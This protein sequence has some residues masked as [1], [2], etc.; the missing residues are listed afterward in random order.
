MVDKRSGLSRLSP[1]RFLL[2][3]LFSAWVARFEMN[4]QLL[5]LALYQGHDIRRH[6]YW[7]EEFICTG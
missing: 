5:E 3:N 7:P 4:G 6:I 2:A 1:C